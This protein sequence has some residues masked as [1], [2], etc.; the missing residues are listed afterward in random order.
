MWIR[1]VGCIAPLGLLVFFGWRQVLNTFMEFFADEPVSVQ[2]QLLTAIVKLF[3]K[4]PGIG[5]PMVTQVG[6]GDTVVVLNSRVW[7]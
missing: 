1:Y 3:L 2:L 4:C 6:R 7:L 5:E